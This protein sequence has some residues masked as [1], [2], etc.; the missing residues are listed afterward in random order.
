MAKRDAQQGAGVESGLC[1][2]QKITDNTPADSV[3]MKK[4]QKPPQPSNSSAPGGH[5][6]RS[7]GG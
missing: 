6:I 1:H 7:Y 2:K 4:S 3:T 5:K